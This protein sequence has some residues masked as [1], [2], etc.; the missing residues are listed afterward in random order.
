M[1][2]PGQWW[3][4]SQNASSG[5][6]HKDSLFRLDKARRLQ[7]VLREEIDRITLGSGTQGTDTYSKKRIRGLNQ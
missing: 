5:H 3:P 4:R 7:A 2:P 1:C 6:R